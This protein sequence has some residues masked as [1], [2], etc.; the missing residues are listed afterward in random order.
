LALIL[1]GWIATSPRAA[2]AALVYVLAIVGMFSISAA[3]HRVRW[4]P[5]AEKWMMRLDHSAIFLFIAA[6]YTPLALLA[7]PPDVGVEVLTI[8][9]SGAAA[10]V[11]FKM[12]WP[13]APRWLGV[14][15][16]LMLGYVAVGFAEPLLVGAGVIVVALLVAGGVLYNIGAI[17]YSTRWPNPWPATFGHHEFFHAFTTAAAICH[18]VAIWLVVQ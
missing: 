4:S 14:S 2:I 5:T 17:L 8:V 18:F 12:L 1:V 13:S 3:Y 10:G 7:L 11:A 16:F 15:L 9:W 6:S